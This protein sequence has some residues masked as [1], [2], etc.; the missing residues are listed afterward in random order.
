[1]TAVSKLEGEFIRI[2][3]L[4]CYDALSSVFF[5]PHTLCQQPQNLLTSDCNCK[6]VDHCV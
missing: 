1:M 4:L 5:E 2:F 6:Q 3:A